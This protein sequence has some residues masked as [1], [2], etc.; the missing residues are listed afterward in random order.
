MTSALLL[1]ALVGLRHATD[2]DHLAA[3]STLVAREPLARRATSLG[4][5]WSLGHGTTLLGVGGAALLL[6]T[7][8][9]PALGG[10]AEL[11]VAL[12]LVALGVSNLRHASHPSPHASAASERAALVRS[13]FVG[14]AHGAAGS[15]LIAVAAAAAMPTTGEALLYLVAFA[16]GTALAMVA[17]STLLAAPLRSLA[18]EPQ[19]HRWVH[20]VTGAISL[21]VGLGLAFETV[22]AWSLA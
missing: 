21:L 1:G 11:G 17:F 15:G 22:Q 7:R 20:R 3:V 13:G 5:A 19:R 14:L 9:P 10:L 2:P 12:V 18:R 8:L 6:S 16:L 4:A